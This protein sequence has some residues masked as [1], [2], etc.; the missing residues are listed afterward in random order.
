[1]LPKLRRAWTKASQSDHLLAGILRDVGYASATL[2]GESMRE[3]RNFFATA[4]VKSGR[5]EDM[6]AGAIEVLDGQRDA[7]IELAKNAAVAFELTNELHTGVLA[8]LQGGPISPKQ[9]ASVLLVTPSEVS[10]A[11]AKLRKLGLVHEPIRNQADRRMLH[12][13]LTPKG[14]SVLPTL[15]QDAPRVPVPAPHVEIAQRRQV[16]RVEYNSEL[17]PER[18]DARTYIQ[19]LQRVTPSKSA[20]IGETRDSEP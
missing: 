12:Y 3:V 5:C 16:P 19:L 6:L 1:M 4:A 9:L 8:R 18:V 14:K 13:R 10:N 20:A 17:V 7:Q 15:Q 11:L 2:D